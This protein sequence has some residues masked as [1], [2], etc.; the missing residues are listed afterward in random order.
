MTLGKIERFW[1][2]LL[3]EFL[4]RAQSDSFEQAVERT[5]LWVRITT[6]SGPSRGRGSVAGGPLL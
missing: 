2:S 4:Q 6:T 3:G 1:K 5:A